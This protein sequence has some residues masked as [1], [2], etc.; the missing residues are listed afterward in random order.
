MLLLHTCKRAYVT[1]I[2]YIDVK[3]LTLVHCA[4]ALSV[5]RIPLYKCMFLKHSP[6]CRMQRVFKKAN[7]ERKMSAS[8]CV[9]V[10]HG[11][12]TVFSMIRRV[13][14]SSCNFTLYICYVE[15][16]ATFSQSIVWY[17][18]LSQNMTMV[19]RFKL[20]FS[21][22]DINVLH[23]RILLIRFHMCVYHLFFK[24]KKTLKF[25][26]ILCYLRETE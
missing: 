3:R 19:I 26:Y 11:I 22:L 23:K 15:C 5:L 8:L 21:S 17:T 16:V 12:N 13:I 7:T 1:F 18:I 14:S 9:C 10:K 6:L 2:H 20:P 4:L 24:Y 25:L